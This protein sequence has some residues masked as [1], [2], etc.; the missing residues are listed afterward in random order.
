ML[1]G[2]WYFSFNLILMMH[3]TNSQD[4]KNILRHSFL[5]CRIIEFNVR[6]CNS[7]ASDLLGK[8]MIILLDM[9]LQNTAELINGV[10]IVICF[11][12][13][14]SLNW[15]FNKPQAISFWHFNK[16]RTT[17]MSNDVSAR[18]QAAMLCKTI[19]HFAKVLKSFVKIYKKIT[20]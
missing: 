17:N 15:P 13:F 14:F 1:K 18:I 7:T 9:I 19:K 11:W 6:L 8:L 10:K 16:F 3:V 12:I 4:P 2:N 5:S 20:N